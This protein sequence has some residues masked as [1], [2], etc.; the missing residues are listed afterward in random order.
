MSSIENIEARIGRRLK[1]GDVLVGRRKDGGIVL[2]EVTEP[3]VRTKDKK[4]TNYRTNGPAVKTREL[5]RCG[6]ISSEE[7]ETERGWNVLSGIVKLEDRT[8]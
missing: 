1:K 7:S 6:P 3:F 4:S 8:A 5:T 2:N